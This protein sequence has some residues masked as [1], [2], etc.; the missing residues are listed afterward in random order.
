[1]C[2]ETV[3]TKKWSHFLFNL[4]AVIWLFLVKKD[5]TYL[6]QMLHHATDGTVGILRCLLGTVLME[7]GKAREYIVLS[8]LRVGHVRE[9]KFCNVKSAG[10]QFSFF[11]SLIF[12][13]WLV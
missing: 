11:F 3:Q 7:G 1:M 2:M 12:L 4:P 6:C 10:E 9:L 8:R 5:V 13:K